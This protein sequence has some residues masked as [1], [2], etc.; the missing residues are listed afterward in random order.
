ME[1]LVLAV[2]QFVSVNMDAIASALAQGHAS[3]KAQPPDALERAAASAAI[4]ESLGRARGPGT[5]HERTEEMLRALVS[6]GPR[7]LGG[8]EEGVRVRRLC[9]A[10]L[11]LDADQWLLIAKQ[12]AANP[13]DINSAMEFAEAVPYRRLYLPGE[14][15]KAV[16]SVVAMIRA[17]LLERI[18]AL[19]EFVPDE[20]GQF[21]LQRIAREA[22]LRAVFVVSRHDWLVIL[23]E[24]REA[25]RTLHAPFH[26]VVP[27]LPDGRP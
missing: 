13:V 26:D 25:L 20:D 18:A 1:D 17:P 5:S 27:S 23:P 15:D 16:H 14:F 11:T 21:P 2:R 8:E 10:L 7:A 22:A 9:D 6:A 19:P 12:Y 4:S 24:G 3:P